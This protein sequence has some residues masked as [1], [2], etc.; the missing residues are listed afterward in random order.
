MP[1]FLI[2][3]SLI[4]ENSCTLT[5]KDAHHLSRVLRAQ[6]GEN[7]RLIDNKGNRYEGIVNGVRRHEVVIEELKPM[8]PL[9]PPYPVHLFCSLLKSEKMEGIVQKACEL[10]IEAIH[11]VQ[12]RRS[13]LH[14]ISSAKWERLFRIAQS[15]QK[16][17]GRAIPLNLIAPFPVE[18]LIRSLSKTM[19]HF[20]FVENTELE[21][22]RHLIK[23][24][25]VNPPYGLW[26]GPEGGWEI[27]EVEL[28]SKNGFLKA[29]LGPLVLR[30]ET[31]AIHAVSTLLA[32]AF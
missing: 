24:Y 23:H 6:Q 19:S 28:A 5:G 4:Q 27:L 3:P 15:A 14:H 25:A 18:T 17:C 1:T 20:I 31:A 21:S 30:A 2:D 16:Q 13:V 10:N 22:A 11:F 12:T 26:V 9:P 32:L 7:V 29:T 8:A